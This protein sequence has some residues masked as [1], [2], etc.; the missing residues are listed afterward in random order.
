MPT[1]NINT[2]NG[3][4]NTKAP[5]TVKG[6]TSTSHL[7]STV[8]Y[9]IVCVVAAFT[10]TGNNTTLLVNRNLAAAKGTFT[11]TG[12]NTTLLVK[13]NLTSA[14]GTFVLSGINSNLLVN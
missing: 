13:R 7:G 12:N 3:V 2:A 10:L 8:S 11:L 4:Q 6:F 5:T 9:S 1:I 14:T